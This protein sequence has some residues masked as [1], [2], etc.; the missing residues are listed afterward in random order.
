[1]ARR[2]KNRRIEPTF[3]APAARRGSDDLKL[4]DSDRVVP[5]TL[6]GLQHRLARLERDVPLGRQASHQHTHLRLAHQ[7][8][9]VH[10]TADE[11]STPRSCLTRLRAEE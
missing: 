6:Q 4:G 1:M 3:D 7:D 8:L 5:A 9:P 10:V 2:T 11:S